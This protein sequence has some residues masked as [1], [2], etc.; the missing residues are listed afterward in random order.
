MLNACDAFSFQHVFDAKDVK[1]HFLCLS[2]QQNPIATSG[3]T[4][5]R[6]C[7]PARQPLK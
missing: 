1:D 5:L 4:A 6:L 3:N 7:L 2:D